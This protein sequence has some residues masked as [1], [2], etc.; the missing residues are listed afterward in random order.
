MWTAS[1]LLRI[2]DGDLTLVNA[3]TWQWWQAVANENF[4]SGLIYT[5]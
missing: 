3:S 4:K 2:I 1:P 5:D